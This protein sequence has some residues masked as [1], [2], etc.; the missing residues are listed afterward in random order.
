MLAELRILITV[1]LVISSSTFCFALEKSRYKLSAD[2]EVISLTTKSFG[3][4]KVV[5]VKRAGAESFKAMVPGRRG[6]VYSFRRVFKRQNQRRKQNGKKFITRSKFKRKKARAVSECNKYNLSE[7]GDNGAQTPQPD[8]NGELT[9]T[10]SLTPT[11][12]S[13][14]IPDITATPTPTIVATITSTATPTN[15]VDP[16]SCEDLAPRS[17]DDF[18]VD[19]DSRCAACSDNNPGTIEEPWC[20]IQ[21]AAELMT[22]GQT[23]Y[24]LE[25]VYNE[26]VRMWNS[27]TDNAPITFSVYPGNNVTLDGSQRLSGWRPCSSQASCAGAPA[28]QNLFY[29]DLPAGVSSTSANLYVGNTLAQVAQDPNPSEPLLFLRREPMRLVPQG[30]ATETTLSDP[31]YFTQNDPHYWDGAY[32][33]RYGGNNN[34]SVVPITGYD[35]A[36]STITYERISWP[37]SYGYDRYALLNHPGLIDQQNEYYVD[38]QNGRIYL[39]PSSIEELEDTTVSTLDIGFYFYDHSF[40]TV[41]GFTI[42][43]FSAGFKEYNRGLA[44]KTI[45]HK[46]VRGLKVLN[47]SITQNWSFEK[48]RAIHLSGAS[49]S[50]VDGNTIYNSYNGGIFFSGTGGENARNVTISNNH[51]TQLAGTLYTFYSVSD[52]RIINNTAIDSHGLHANGITAYID[53]DGVLI[54]GNTIIDAQIAV[55]FQA[56]SNITIRNNFLSGGPGYVLAGWGSLHANGSNPRNFTIDHN[57]IIGGSSYINDDL[58]NTVITNNI[59]DGFCENGYLSHSHNLILKPSW[60]QAVNYSGF[61]ESVESDLAA[62]FV[63]HLN[64]DYRARSHIVGEPPVN[65]CTM[66][67]SMG[68][69]G[70]LGCE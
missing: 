37:I 20:T 35:P 13:T 23:A 69:V 67:D 70:A 10:P 52:G 65:P 33:L 21:H 7:P 62:V 57:T 26:S 14:P 53:C 63:D 30:A 46:P 64:D 5:C 32:L 60:C 48:A 56:S 6:F 31:E 58:R 66:S 38:D 25:G 47:S 39:W 29:T 27:G 50:I 40:I 41:D 44:F 3:K 49:D 34:T 1:M 2:D 18:Y 22:A 55:T 19:G 4:S 12:A 36:T 8:D 16:L 68:A 59:L 51:C 17:S 11:K 61:N 28:W 42:K 15:T 45:G 43:R 54:E 9:P 24:V